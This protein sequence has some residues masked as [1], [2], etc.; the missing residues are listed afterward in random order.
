M[1]TVWLQD[2]R[3]PRW[4]F[5]HY[6]CCFII[7]ELCNLRLHYFMSFL[8]LV[9]DYKCDTGVPKLFHGVLIL[10]TVLRILT[11]TISDQVQ[12]DC[13]SRQAQ[14]P[15]SG[16]SHFSS[17][18]ASSMIAH[19]WYRVGTFYR[20]YPG[21]Y[22]VRQE[23][24]CFRRGLQKLALQWLACQARSSAGFQVACTRKAHG[25]RPLLTNARY[26]W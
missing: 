26:D 2:W 14:V 20:L 25:K 11:T 5:A 9:A 15:K 22:H 18:F 8:L 21:H 16:M 12:C 13:I 23:I 1:L 7:L 4:F 17:H 24:V 3:N 19:H 6:I 10:A